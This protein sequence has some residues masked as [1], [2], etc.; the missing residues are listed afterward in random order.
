MKLPAPAADLKDSTITSPTFLKWFRA[1]V[2]VDD[3]GIALPVYHG[4]HVAFDEFDMTM[5]KD[6]AHFFTPLDS[7]AAHFGPM[8][9]Y[10]VRIE[11]PL[12]ISQIDLED[13]WDEEH[14]DGEQDDRCLLP[15]D[16]VERFVTKAKESGHDGLVVK[17]FGDLDYC[18]DVYLPFAPNQIKS[19]TDNVGIFDDNCNDVTDRTSSLYLAVKGADNEVGNTSKRR[20]RL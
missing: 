4:S 12:M 6:G 3:H 5:A 10:F 14:P 15:R 1:S 9:E 16:F 18:V 2:V 17:D 13:V 7:H 20:L 8:R 11:N 19:S